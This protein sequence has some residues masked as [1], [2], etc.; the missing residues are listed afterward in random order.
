MEIRKHP[1]FEKSQSTYIGKSLVVF[2]VALF[3]QMFLIEKLPFNASFAIFLLFIIAFV[4]N[5]YY[6]AYIRPSKVV[7]PS[8]NSNTLCKTQKPEGFMIA[9]CKYCKVKWDLGYR[10]SSD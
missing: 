2:S 9:V 5:F 10:F 3:A 1:T 8:C 6:G 7:C 4:A